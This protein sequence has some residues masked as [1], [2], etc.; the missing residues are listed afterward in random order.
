MPRQID[1]VGVDGGNRARVLDRL[2]HVE[3]GD[4]AR[5]VRD[6]AAHPRSDCDALAVGFVPLAWPDD[7][8]HVRGRQART[9]TVE[10]DVKRVRSATIPPRRKAHEIELQ[11]TVDARLARDHQRALPVDEE[12]AGLVG[13]VGEAGLDRAQIAEQL[14]RL[15]R[16]PVAG[17]AQLQQI[18]LA[19]REHGLQVR[20]VEL[21]LLRR[22]Q[23][24]DAGADA[25]GDR[26]EL[27][28]GAIA[29]RW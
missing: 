1:A 24:R 15:L 5:L 16:A 25:G 17:E 22:Q 28:C 9:V 19:Q 7:E 26:L 10:L 2:E 3:L 4:V 18:A 20:A 13:V 29:A 23:P 14:G 11:R 6:V 8:A 12:G 27:G 21:G